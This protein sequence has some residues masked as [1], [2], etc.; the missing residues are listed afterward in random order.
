MKPYKK[1]WT[2]PFVALLLAISAQCRAEDSD[3][4]GKNFPAKLEHGFANM[5][6]G[7]LE[8]PKNV[9]N[10]SADSNIL[11]GI[12]WGTLRG[13]LHGVSRTLVGVGDFL[14][15]PFSTADYVSPGYPWERFSEDTRYFGKAYPGYWTSFGPMDPMERLGS[16]G[17][18]L[19]ME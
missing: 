5:T 13:A 10:I 15:S 14:S 7:M 8:L 2:L 12:T 16:D 9:I 1:T 4:Y 17:D 19:R 3:G 18:E 6:M 11:V